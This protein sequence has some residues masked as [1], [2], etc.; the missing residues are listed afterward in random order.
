MGGSHGHDSTYSAFPK[1]GGT[2]SS[3]DCG[4]IS[5]S[6]L[7]SQSKLMYAYRILNS[8]HSTVELAGL[9]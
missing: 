2:C 5:A 8:C 7:K 6:S 1:D 3:F 9:T 4:S